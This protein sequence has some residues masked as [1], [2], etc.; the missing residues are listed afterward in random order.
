MISRYQGRQPVRDLPV[1]PNIQL[2]CDIMGQIKQRL[3]YVST[4]ITMAKARA[5]YMNNLAVTEF[6]FLQY[7][8]ICELIALGCIAIH[9][10]IEQ[11]KKLQKMWNAEEVMSTFKHLK[12]GYFP[13]KVTEKAQGDGTIAH[14]DV[15]DGVLNADTLI[16]LYNSCG[17]N[18]HVGTFKVLTESKKD[19]LDFAKL[20]K[21][22][23]DL[24]SLLSIH[25]FK[26]YDT[27]ML[28]KIEMNNKDGLVEWMYALSIGPDDIPPPL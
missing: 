22:A 19:S 1:P 25:T 4:T 16:V 10:D 26:L 6:C 24:Q 12:P 23:S 2:Y 5:H 14:T 7:R 17:R 20:E 27:D 8:F 28:I 13:T 11:P 21:I 3:Q 18:L 9:T 15:I